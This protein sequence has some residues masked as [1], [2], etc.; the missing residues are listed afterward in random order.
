[1]HSQ[2]MSVLH[3]HRYL[4][5][6]EGIPSFSMIR[7]CFC[8]TSTM[9]MRKTVGD[10]WGGDRGGKRREG[11]GLEMSAAGPSILK[12]QRMPGSVHLICGWMSRPSVVSSVE[13]TDPHIT[14]F[15]KICLKLHSERFLSKNSPFYQAKSQ[16]RAAV[17]MNIWIPP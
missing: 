1:M 9:E 7:C 13:T 6:A 5:R 14:L 10:E 11:I 17:E 3:L 15:D 8:L 2:V 16:S 12:R 4:H